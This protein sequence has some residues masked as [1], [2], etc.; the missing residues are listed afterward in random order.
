MFSLAL[1]R[2]YPFISS[3]LACFSSDDLMEMN[4]NI[5]RSEAAQTDACVNETGCKMKQAS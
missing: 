3:Q 5:Y 4:G 1:N 2:V